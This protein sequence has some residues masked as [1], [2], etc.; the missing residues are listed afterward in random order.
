MLCPPPLYDIVFEQNFLVIKLNAFKKNKNKK[1][2]KIT[3]SLG[4]IS[5]ICISC[6]VLK[7]VRVG[8]I[9]RAYGFTC[10]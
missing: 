3:C 8:E 4:T 7:K 6:A 5:I 1:H 9:G 2:F 10:S